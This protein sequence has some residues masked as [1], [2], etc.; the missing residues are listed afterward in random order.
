MPVI[1]MW[2]TGYEFQTE[3]TTHNRIYRLVKNERYSNIYCEK[4]RL[5]QIAYKKKNKP[6][7][8]TFFR[9]KYINYK[10]S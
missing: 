4:V 10:A 2:W 1:T 9:P 8:N 3:F 7:Q 5:S 6:N